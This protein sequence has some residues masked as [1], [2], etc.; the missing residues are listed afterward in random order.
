MLN[1][2][3]T[4]F[5]DKGL[6]LMLKKKHFVKQTKIKVTEQSVVVSKTKVKKT[7]FLIKI[8][9]FLNV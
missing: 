7:I 6:T 4:G 8:N 9:I 5:F 1:M 3:I 2:M